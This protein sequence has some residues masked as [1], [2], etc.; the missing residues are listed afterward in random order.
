MHAAAPLLLLPQVTEA[1]NKAAAQA[2]AAASAPP[3][4]HP[5]HGDDDP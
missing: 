1:K 5:D 4:P 2:A 3:H